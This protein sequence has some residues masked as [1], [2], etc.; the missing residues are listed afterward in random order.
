MARAYIEQL[1]D[2]DPDVV[3]Y[4]KMPITRICRH[5]GGKS[6]IW[7]STAK[8][9]QY[10]DERALV[11]ELWP[12]ASRGACET[13]KTGYHSSCFDQLFIKESI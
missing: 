10:S 3:R 11:Q 4:D 6:V 8:H 9:M 1:I 12:D 13:F 7:C 2:L 5:C